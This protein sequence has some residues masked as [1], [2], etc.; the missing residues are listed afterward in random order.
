MS[1]LFQSNN[2]IFTFI[3]ILS[4][5]VLFILNFPKK[6]IWINS[7]QA[8][9]IANKEGATWLDIRS[10]KLFKQGHIAQA[11]N[12]PLDQLKTKILSLSKKKPLI[13]ISASDHDINPTAKLLYSEGFLKVFAIAGG[14]NSWIDTNL[15]IITE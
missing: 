14:M 6:D 9:N 3:A 12:I 10:S 7:T 2:I 5:I 8:I 11:K 1:F 13:L 15:P 4:G